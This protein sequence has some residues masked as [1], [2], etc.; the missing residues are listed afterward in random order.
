MTPS[1]RK[2]GPMNQAESP[3]AGP[4]RRVLVVDDDSDAL[5]ILTDFLEAKGIDVIGAV[6]G[7]EALTR[8]HDEGPFDVVVLDVMMPGLDGLEVCRRLKASPHGQLTPVLLVSARTDTRSRVAGLYGG[9]DD[10]INKPLDLSEF[11]ARLE[12]LIRV[13]DRYR[14]LAERRGE[15]IETALTDSLTGAANAGYFSRRLR[16]E[17]ARAD[18]YSLPLTVVLA[19][20]IGLPEINP[21][22][23]ALDSPGKPEVFAGPTD[24][25]LVS[26]GHS[27]Q[28]SVRAHDLV[29][30]LRRG[31]FGILLPH[32]SKR[33]VQATVERLLEVA[34]KIPAQPGAED[35]P[36]AGLSLRTGSAE[37]GPRMDEVTLLARAEPL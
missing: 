28:S 17:I 13:R 15:A 23:E 22:L 6:D 10:Y 36:P 1:G 18:R 32:T 26:L 11:L 3:D 9:A 27:L 33:T 14:D 37:L 24:Q 2:K 20:V 7:H 8:F 12:V 19:D 29:A 30:R 21:H 16:E 5:R 4:Q 34:L 31:R 25:L 35:G